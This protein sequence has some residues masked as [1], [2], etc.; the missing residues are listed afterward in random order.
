MNVLPSFATKNW[1]F[2]YLTL[3][4][5]KMERV[6]EEFLSASRATN[7][8]NSERSLE[9]FSAN[10]ALKNEL[11]ATEARM[12]KLGKQLAHVREIGLSGLPERARE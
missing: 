3:V 8:R 11:V 5:E 12:V 7:K 6:A 10:K 1:D 2:F 9:G 4:L